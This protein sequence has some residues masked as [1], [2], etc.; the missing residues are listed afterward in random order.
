MYPVY[1]LLAFAAAAALQ[2]G[3]NCLEAA[4][5]ALSRGVSRSK[6]AL[7]AFVYF[8]AAAVSVCLCGSRVLSNRV[9]YGGDSS[10]SISYRCL[11]W[12]RLLGAVERCPRAHRRPAGRQ[13]RRR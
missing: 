9:N 3:A 10:H 8:V 6:G 5:G 4:V 2:S 7:K 13:A 11:T 1:P 12:H